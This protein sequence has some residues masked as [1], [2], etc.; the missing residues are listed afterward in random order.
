MEAPDA[1]T[2]QANRRILAA[3]AVFAILLCAA[4]IL[5]KAFWT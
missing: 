3:I 4:V 5:W 2:R 1:K